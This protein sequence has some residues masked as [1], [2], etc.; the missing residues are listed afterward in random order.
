MPILGQRIVSVVAC[1]R[2][3]VQVTVEHW[4]RSDS[5]IRDALGEWR[6]IYGVHCPACFPLIEI[7]Q[8]RF[9]AGKPPLDRLPDKDTQDEE[10]S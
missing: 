10:Y 4:S 3:G 9:M 8:L 6:F 2:C 1:D 5:S 7:N